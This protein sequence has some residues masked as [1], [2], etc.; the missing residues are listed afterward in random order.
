MYSNLSRSLEL[1][2]VAELES[3]DAQVGLRITRYI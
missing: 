2:S 1:Q 3:L